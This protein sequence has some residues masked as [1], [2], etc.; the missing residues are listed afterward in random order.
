MKKKRFVKDFD[1]IDWD[2][3]YRGK[4]SVH[5]NMIIQT[6]SPENIF[7]EKWE[8]NSFIDQVFHPERK[9]LVKV[10]A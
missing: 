9:K 2:G 5:G 10:K 3:F 7:N 1:Y 6:V 8:G 4:S